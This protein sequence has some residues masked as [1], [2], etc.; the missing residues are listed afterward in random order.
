LWAPPAGAVSW[1]PRSTT[2]DQT[3]GQP[4]P[5]RQSF[6]VGRSTWR[7]R[8]SNAPSRTST[9]GRSAISTWQDVPDGGH[10]EVPRLKGGGEYRA[11]DTIDNAPEER[12]RGITIAI[13][14]WSTRRRPATTPTSTARPRDYIKNMITGA[15]QMDGHLVVAATDGRCPRPA[16]TSCSPARARS[17]HRRLPQQ[18][19]RGRRSELLDL[20]ELESASC[21]EEQFPGD[22]IPFMPR[23]GLKPWRPRTTRRPGLRLHPGAHGCRRRVHPTPGASGRQAF[24]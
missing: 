9:S 11:F 17:V 5:S 4:R 19:R 16:S 7:R 8:S 6:G 14:T 18:G 15:A 23:L 21:Y 2:G 12:E 24:S 20:V 10:H 3:P 1:A 22:D 13:A